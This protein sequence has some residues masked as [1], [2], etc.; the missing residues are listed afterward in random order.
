MSEKGLGDRTR[1]I[2]V[3]ATTALVL[4]FV[5]TQI[6]GK[7]RIV[8]HGTTVLLPLLLQDPRSLLQG[9]Y[10]AL[11]YAMSAQVADAA[12]AAGVRTGRAVIELD[13][14]QRARFV[15][16]H[17]GGPLGANQYLLAF[18]KRGETVRLASDAYFFEEGHWERFARAR[19]GELRVAANGEAVLVGLRDGEGARI[20]GND[21][22][23]P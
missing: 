22:D 6:A 13:D 11:R 8:R 17:A 7:E 16:L 19:F 4:A 23:A 14:V 18:R 3:V 5:N 2:V 15:A 9:D 1:L 12:D 21:S 20:S 10:M